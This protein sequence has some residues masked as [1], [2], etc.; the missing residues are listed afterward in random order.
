MANLSSALASSK[1]DADH[2]TGNGYRPG[3][4]RMEHEDTA[5]ICLWNA[6]PADRIGQPAAQPAYVCIICG[7]GSGNNGRGSGTVD[8]I[9]ASIPRD[10]GGD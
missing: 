7:F 1:L 2:W 3:F 9:P 10:D 8:P 6:V 4:V 5:I